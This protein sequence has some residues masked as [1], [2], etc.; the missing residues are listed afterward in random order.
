MSQGSLCPTPQAHQVC[1]ET[2]PHLHCEGAI[3]PMEVHLWLTGWGLR[4]WGAGH[5]LQLWRAWD[6]SL[7]SSWTLSLFCLQTVELNR[8]VHLK[9]LSVSAVSFLNHLEK[10]TRLKINLKYS[11]QSSIKCLRIFL[12][13]AYF[14]TV[15][16]LDFPAY[17]TLKVFGTGLTQCVLV[18]L[19]VGGF[20]FYRST[21]SPIKP[22]AIKN[23]KP[24]IRTE[25]KAS[26]CKKGC[27]QYMQG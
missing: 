4:G 16:S 19:V 9:L 13:E 10:K 26:Q 24:K 12:T 5:K 8:H 2:N 21:N 1:C 3:Q 6:G 18:G 27:F 15:F 20:L 23:P 11:I 22:P 14:N 17:L 25:K 7:C